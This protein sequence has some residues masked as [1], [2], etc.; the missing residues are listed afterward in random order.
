[1]RTAGTDFKGAE[2]ISQFT[3][4]RPRTLLLDYDGTLAPFRVERDEARPYPQAREALENVIR[5][6]RT[7]VVIISGRAIN[8]LIPL[9]GLNPS[10]EIWGS[11]GWERRTP[12]GSYHGP[13]LDESTMEA[14]QAA[15]LWAEAAG[16]GE[17]F[18]EKPASVAIHWRGMDK[19]EAIRLCEHA[20]DAWAPLTAGAAMELR[21]FDG[22][23][24]LCATGRDKG[25]AVRTILD[26]LSPD[27]L[28]AYAGDDLTDE[29]AF[30]ALNGRGLSILVR[31]AY[32]ETAADIW[33]QP[34]GELVRFLEA[35]A[36]ADGEGE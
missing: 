34:P 28:V 35:W 6:G 31:D 23:L 2:F 1:M 11:H 26:E 22:G 27:T 8:D 29:D 14:L 20:R 15:K 16:C 19:D 3:A 36:V 13:Q 9:M 5:A 7:R 32:R 12:D 4:A 10:P 24:E 25:Y 30:K 17:R 18:E 33:L 21:D